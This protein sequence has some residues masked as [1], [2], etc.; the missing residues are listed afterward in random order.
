MG[1]FADKD[2]NG[3]GSYACYL[4]RSSVKCKVFIGGE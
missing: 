1:V 3:A 4:T 2:H